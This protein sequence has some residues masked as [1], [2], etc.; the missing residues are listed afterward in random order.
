MPELPEVQ[1]FINLLKTQ[2]LNHSIIEVKVFVNK[3]LKNQTTQQFIATL[4]NQ[5]FNNITRIG[6]YLIFH[7][8]NNQVMVLHLRMEGKVFYQHQSQSYDVN[9]V[10]LIIQFDNGYQL[11]YHDT[12]RFGTIHI[13]SQS[14]YLNSREL[15]KIGI[16]PI[17]DR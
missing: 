8:S 9:H 14:N 1:T 3:L 2:V 5:K 16:D 15:A 12:R 4:T 6:K 13:F 17:L 7:L 10:L 11:R